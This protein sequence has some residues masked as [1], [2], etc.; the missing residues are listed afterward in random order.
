MLSMMLRYSQYSE[1]GQKALFPL[2]GGFFGV[3]WAILGDLDYMVK[4]LDLPNFKS[5]VNPCT[6][7]KCSGVGDN[8][9]TDFRPNAKWLKQCWTAFEWLAWEDRSKNPLFTL[10]G[11]TCLTVCL[12]YMHMKYLGS[13]QYQFGSVLYV[14]VFK[15]MKSQGSPLENLTRIHHVIRAFYK[16][17]KTPVQYRYLNKLTMFVKKKNFP[18]LR[19]RASEIRHFGPALL[20]VWQ[21]Y[22]NPGILWHR[23][24]ELM[25]KCNIKME[26]ILTNHASAVVLP[27]NAAD[28]FQCAAFSMAQLQ[29]QVAEHF[30][31]E[32][33][34]HLFDITSKIHMVLHT[35]LLSHHISP[36]RVWCFMGED[37]MHC[38]QILATHCA[39]GNRSP[40]VIAKMVRHW[41]L[42]MHFNFTSSKFHSDD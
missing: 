34:Q 31:T 25:L 13:D 29:T 6:L 41:R 42:G 15:V 5:K 3:L 21:H 20:H 18:K 16:V 39:T 7:C 14:L 28:D 10:P 11:V 22:Y 8:S 19:G 38:C 9:W 37:F 30:L 26:R 17:N 27:K 32:G 4:I 1:Q 12:D 24:I 35:A 23:R 36:R 40:D 33:G 2:A